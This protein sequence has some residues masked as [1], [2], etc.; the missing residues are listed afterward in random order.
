MDVT[1]YY[2]ICMRLQVLILLL[3]KHFK[4]QDGFMEEKRR[5]C[6]CQ[7]TREQEKKHINK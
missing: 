4:T 1:T 7:E 3:L 2:H 5:I 6:I